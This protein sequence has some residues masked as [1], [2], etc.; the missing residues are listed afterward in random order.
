VLTQSLAAPGWLTVHHQVSFIRDF[1]WSGQLLLQSK[2][3]TTGVQHV[4]GVHDLICPMDTIPPEKANVKLTQMPTS[5][6]DTLV[7]TTTPHHRSS[8]AAAL[9]VGPESDLPC[10]PPATGCGGITAWS[11][12]CQEGHLGRDH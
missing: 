9:P 12:S 11:L 10:S 1:T 8:E 4:G 7:L 6:S 2:A 5:T 3:S